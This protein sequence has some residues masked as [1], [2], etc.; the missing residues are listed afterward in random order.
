MKHKLSLTLAALALAMT[1]NAQALTT[2]FESTPLGNYSSLTFGTATITYTGGT[3][4][5]QVVSA[6]PGAPI[7][8]HALLSYNINPG[9]APF[10]VDFSGGG[11]SAFSIGVGDYNADADDTHL[12]AY[13]ASDVLLASDD[14]L[15]P[16]SKNGGDYL[17]VSSSSPIAYVTFWDDDPFPGAVYWDNMSVSPVPEPQ[18]YAMLLAG[19]GLLGFVARRKENK[20]DKLAVA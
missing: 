19:L 15:N 2:D 7:S 5:F 17:S 8:G 18:T 3:G 16:S 10:R 9:P 13:S 1:G 12:R 11:A 4:A 14:Y 6:N 20:S